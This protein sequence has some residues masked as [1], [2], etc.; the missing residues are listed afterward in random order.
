M[1]R[2]SLPLGLTVVLLHFSSY[3]PAQSSRLLYS[4]QV[5]L[6]VRA[7]E[8]SHLLPQ[9]DATRLIETHEG[10][11]SA[12][13][14][15]NQQGFR[16][17]VRRDGMPHGAFSRDLSVC[18]HSANEIAPAILPLVLHSEPRSVLLLG[19]VTPASLSACTAFPVDKI[20]CML[21][22]PDALALQQDL[23]L[24]TNHKNPFDDDRVDCQVLD[25]VI[26]M[27]AA[28]HQLHDVIV[29]RQEYSAS[30]A[31]G[32]TFTIEF[33]SHVLR[34]LEQQGVFAQQVDLADYG[35]APL[36]NMLSSLQTVFPSVAFVHTSPDKGLLLASP[37]ERVWMDESLARRA[38][39]PH[40]RRLCS[41]VGWDWSVLL[42][43]TST[44]PDS[45]AQLVEGISPLSSQNGDFLCE[46]PVEVLRWAP[47]SQELY[48]TLMPR[49]SALIAWLG[50]ESTARVDVSRR[51]SDM[52]L[53]RQ[54]IQDHPDYYWAYR[55]A[56]KNRLQE[57][58]RNEIIQAA[59]GGLRNGLHPEDQRRKDYFQV[60]AAAA[61][62]AE[63]SLEDISALR[64][65]LEPYDPM[66][67]FFVHQEI[68]RLHERSDSPIVRD[69]FNH[70]LHSVFYGS[71]NDRS[72]R[73]V[74]DSMELLLTY[75]TLIEDSEDR[76]DCFNG[77][78]ELLKY[79]WQMRIQSLRAESRFGPVDATLSLQVAE[80]AMRAMDELQPETTI[81]AADWQARRRVLQIHLI[82]DVDTYRDRLSRQVGR[83]VASN[84]E[85]PSAEE[86][87]EL[88]QA[89]AENA[90]QTDDVQL[91]ETVTGPTE[92]SV[93]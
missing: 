47:K 24:L 62:Q 73:N 5:F 88:Q 70:L 46:F 50:D 37:T 43:L 84:P 15:W 56:L 20:T 82:H 34:H 1:L 57:R 59:G 74:V 61:T 40:V 16:V 32:G 49:S 80:Q 78:L 8:Q 17:S 25:P 19:T 67:S 53:Q 12:W 58:P 45:V 28:S 91:I 48:M 23:A 2:W 72:V 54:T 65:F 9:L 14:V 83:N 4:T 22:D 52:T 92:E 30:P 68:A 63:P 6:A 60:L 42:S 51:L 33:Y 85:Q 75:P 3:S 11:E 87:R 10:R 77:L 18:P 64:D 21:R 7:G 86:L 81:S 29:C 36:L 71:G 44:P 41:Q 35:A 13:T 89:A 76:F 69:E 38:E 31:D 90:P 66:V 27:R 26:G 79:R 55:V 39:A 93:Q